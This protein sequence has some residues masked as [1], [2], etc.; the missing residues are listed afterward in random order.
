[1]IWLAI[2]ASL[3]AAWLLAPPAVHE[4]LFV[5]RWPFWFGGPAIGLF[6]LFF[7]WGDGRQLGVSS[8]YSDACSAAFDPGTR[9]SWRLIFLVGLVGGGALSALLA[10]G[11]EPTLAMGS[12]DTAVSSAPLTKA[13][14]FGGGGVLIGLGARLADGC[15]SGH[16]IVGTALLAPASWIATGAFM[17][18]GVLTAHLLFA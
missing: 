11:I 14:L 9:R 13:L 7:L 18:A 17:V 5:S 2:V 6:V 12:F 8:G 1:M 3:G 15:T 4:A 16:G 10:G